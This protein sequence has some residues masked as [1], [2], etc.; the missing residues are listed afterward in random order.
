[1]KIVNA[2]NITHLV[3]PKTNPIDKPVYITLSQIEE[4]FVNDDIGDETPEGSFGVFKIEYADGM[5]EIWFD[6]PTDLNE[7]EALELATRILS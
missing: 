7:D 4:K 1:M 5:Q 3:Y 6:Y 2:I